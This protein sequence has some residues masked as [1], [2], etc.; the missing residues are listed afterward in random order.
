MVTRVKKWERY[1]KKIEKM[2]DGRFPTQQGVEVEKKAA[3][4]F[5]LASAS[6]AIYAIDST[7]IGIKRR[8]PHL[9]FKGKRKKLLIL[10]I[11]VFILV[12]TIVAFILL[13]MLWVARGN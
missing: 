2:P 1:R 7:T 10:I 13:W 6:P 4:D 9:F 11:K 8:T 3:D 12:L 5:V